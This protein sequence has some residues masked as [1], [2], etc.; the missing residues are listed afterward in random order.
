VDCNEISVAETARQLKDAGF[1]ADVRMAN[2]Y[3]PS[4]AELGKFDFVY[5]RFV[6]QH[7]SEP[8]LALANLRNC[9]AEGGRLCLCDVDDRWL[10][11]EPAPPE[12][13]SFLARVARAQAA[14][15]GDRHVGSKLAHYLQRAGYGEIRCTGLLLSSDMI[16]KEAFCDLVFGYKLEVIP[17]GE[18]AEAREELECIKKAVHSSHGWAG[19]MA[20]F[21]SGQV[22]SPGG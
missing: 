5:S 1:P 19:V 20:L 21:I 7:L 15:G 18:L 4:V 22:A 8:L 13:A 17:A 9:L 11:V 12:L 3:D 16:G 10:S 14:R 6:F 2:L